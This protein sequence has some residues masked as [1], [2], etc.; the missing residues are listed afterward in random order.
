MS[1]S[2][3]F[4]V[5]LSRLVFQVLGARLQFCSKC[6]QISVVLREAVQG[7]AKFHGTFASNMS[8][9]FAEVPEKLRN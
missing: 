7:L 4:F 5:K 1:I 9:Q 2:D 6:D 3:R 8:Q